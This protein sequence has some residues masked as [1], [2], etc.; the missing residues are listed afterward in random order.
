MVSLAPQDYWVL[1]ILIGRE[2][3]E[4]KAKTGEETREFLKEDQTITLD[5]LVSQIGGCKIILI[6]G[7]T[8]TIGMTEDQEVDTS[9]VTAT[10][11]REAEAGQLITLG[12]HLAMRDTG[13]T[14]AFS[15]ARGIQTREG[16]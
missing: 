2:E 9:R 10:V 1:G 16:F 13:G 6:T 5:P 11:G 14:G 7:T 8:L 12:D 4:T 15:E 3:V